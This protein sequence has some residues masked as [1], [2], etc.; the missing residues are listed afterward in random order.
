MFNPI[1]KHISQAFEGLPD[2]R[3]ASNGTKYQVSDAAKSAFSVFF[4]QSPSF[5]AQQQEMKRKRGRSNVESLFGAHE[6]PSDNQIRNILDPI[7]PQKISGVFWEIYE[8]LQQTGVLSSYRDINDTLLCGI[9]GTQ[10]FSSYEIGCVHCQQKEKVGKVLYSHS[11]IAPVLVA[12]GCEQVISL[13]PEFIWPQDGREKQDCEQ[14]ALKRW[15]E[16]NAARF[17]PFSLTLL[18]DDLHSRQPT[19]ELCLAHKLNFVFVCKPD[20]HP[21]LYEEIALLAQID[22]IASLVVRRWNGHFHEVDTY[23]YASALPLRVGDD[24]LR[25]QWCE[26]TTVHEKTGA[27]L[28]RNS[29]LTNFALT[30]K[31]VVATVR[32]GRAR[33]K[34]EN[35]N[36]QTLK[37]H[38]YHLEHNFGHGSRY[39]SMILLTLNLLAFLSHTLLDLTD[40]LYRQI[41]QA[42]HSRQTFFND[43]RALTRYLS[44]DSWSHLLTFMA[45]QL[46]LDIP[47]HPA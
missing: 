26:L 33:W 4:M 40:P 37:Q 5:L 29:F 25:I 34:S 42:L 38:G 12:P 31:T 41:R 18:A 3:K 39:L 30:D 46:E 13:E 9:D 19:C 35:E 36:H 27:I 23:R 2:Y 21:T 47:P 17:A 28:Y 32:A 45:Q 44:F 7:A 10:Y 24:A 1:I 43:L 11:V 22:A 20:S 8:I 16:R 14:N 15:I 6:P